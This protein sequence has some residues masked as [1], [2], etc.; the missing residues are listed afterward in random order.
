[1]AHSIACR[2]RT[3]TGG[4]TIADAQ[5]PTVVACSGGPDSCG[6]VLALHAYGGVE[7]VVHVVHDLRPRDAAMADRDV[8]AGLARRL[9][10]AFAERHIEVASMPGN[11]EAV[12]RAARYDALAALA[13]QCGARFIATAHHADDQLETMLLRLTRGAGPRALAGIKSRRRL[14]NGTVVIRPALR[15]PRAELLEMCKLA[16]VAFAHDATNLDTTRARGFLRANVAPA[17]EALSPGAARHAA[18]AADRQASVSHFLG[19]HAEAALQRCTISSE[20]GVRE[21]DRAMLR[22]EHRAIVAEV[23]VLASRSVADREGARSLHARSVE[24]LTSAVR[25][26]VGGTREFRLGPATARLTRDRV[27]I[28]CSPPR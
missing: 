24:S 18:G 3:L 2:W 4:P 23:L 10:L 12:A 19:L 16:G 26:T 20:A 14:E 9:G 28:S 7:A 21:L 27:E 22:A 11:A 17:L 1:M 25:G 6:L 5:R 13:A 8:A 15:T